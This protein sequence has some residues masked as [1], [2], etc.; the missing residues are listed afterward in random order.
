MA[1]SVPGKLTPISLT[2]FCVAFQDEKH[3]LP[4]QWPP[5]HLMR[6]GGEA[7]R[8]ERE[9]SYS[10]EVIYILS[11]HSQPLAGKAPPRPELRGMCLQSRQDKM[12][13]S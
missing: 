6:A 7:G 1:E 12:V 4:Q 5:S 13:A 3:R 2:Q 9:G 10:E 8:V 11:Q